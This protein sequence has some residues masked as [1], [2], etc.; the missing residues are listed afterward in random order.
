MDRTRYQSLDSKI[1]DLENPF[2]SLED[3]RKTENPQ[4]WAAG[5]SFAWGHGLSDGNLPYPELVAERL[6]LQ[7]SILSRPGASIEWSADQLLRSKIKQDDL[8]IWGLSSVNR[9]PWSKNREITHVNPRLF[10]DLKHT[11]D[12]EELKYLKWMFFDENRFRTAIQSVLQVKNFCDQVG[13]HLVLVSHLEL[14]EE[15]YVEEFAKHL[16]KTGCYVDIYNDENFISNLANS[17][18]WRGKHRQY[19]DYGSA[20]IGTRSD[21][22]SCH[23][24]PRTHDIWAQYIENYIKEKKWYV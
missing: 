21:N 24:G 6:N 1:C 16:Q 9:F 8:I 11:I 14:S 4:A 17:I 22:V 13:A 15:H 3:I 18:T 7:C 23:P 19:C 10:E 5:C 12:E 20:D 2:L